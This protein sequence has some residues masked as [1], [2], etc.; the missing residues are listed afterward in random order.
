MLIKA[1]EKSYSHLILESLNVRG[2]L[3]IQ[4]KK[5]Y[6]NQVR[7]F[8]G[9]QWF[10]EFVEQADLQAL[11]I[12][13][14]FLNGPDTNYQFDSVVILENR[15]NIYEVKN[16]TGRYSYRD[17]QLFSENGFRMQD[18]VAQA[19]RKQSYLHN[20]SLARGF[21]CEVNAYVVF[22]NPNFYIYTLPEND[23]I[24]FAGQLEYHLKEL[25]DDSYP[26][27]AQD[28]RLGKLLVRKHHENYRPD[29]LPSYDFETIKKGIRCGK[30][31]S[32]E[33]TKTRQ[34]RFC[35]SCGCIEKISDALYRNIL[36]FQLLFP[37]IPVSVK[38]IREWLDGNY[39]DA[40]IRRVLDN[41][42]TIELYG[43][44]TFY[45]S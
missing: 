3:S 5:Q 33:A 20:F 25:T 8:E 1:R 15:V 38:N 23:D 36:E 21:S 32:F 9:K 17:G 41:N 42:M 11:V 37:E 44:S 12:N 10:D 35:A 28:T 24:I 43:P 34:K 29:N 27:T 14:L 40:R 4:E 30:C 2:E 6:V 7:G 39:S 13:D 31:N 18:P 22:I 45:K 26:I 16:Y 19:K